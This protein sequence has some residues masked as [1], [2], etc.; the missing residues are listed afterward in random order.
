[1]TEGTE[2]NTLVTVIVP[3][4]NAEQYLPQCLE[5]LCCQTHRALEIICVNDGSTDASGHILNEYAARDTRIL[6]L[7]QPNKGQGAAR[8]AGLQ[9]ARGEWIAGLDAD[10]YLEPDALETMLGLVSPTVDIVCVSSAIESARKARAEEYSYLCNTEDRI[11]TQPAEMLEQ[12]NVYFWNKLWRRSFIEQYKLRFTE[13]LW[14]ED[15]AFAHCALPLARAVVLCSQ[16][17]HHY[18]MHEQSIMTHTFNR[19]PRAIEHLNQLEHVLD[20]YR[21][22]GVESRCPDCA[23]TVF[24]CLFGA[25]MAHIPSRWRKTALQ[26]A[27]SI[28]E[29][30]DLRRRYPRE[31]SINA[32]RWV[33]WFL[34]PFFK[35][36]YS[37]R[38]YRFFWIPVL[39][40]K[41]TA[42]KQMWRILGMRIGNLPVKHSSSFYLSLT[43]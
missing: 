37:K 34:K 38:E 9:I 26:K 40:V 22:H 11:L 7:T 28:A 15:S 24:R 5:S 23:A 4:Y 8:N 3:V 30:Y 42:E 36:T 14:Y 16:K 13:G 12:T 1:M 29:Q 39:G 27:A 21:Q 2:Q 20:F 31:G 19:H 10:D 18:R 43:W 32:A 6:V 35:A 17:L 33:P 25:T 41:F